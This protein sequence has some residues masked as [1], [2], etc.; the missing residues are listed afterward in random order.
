MFIYYAIIMCLYILL[1]K[2]VYILCSVTT[3]IIA[4]LHHAADIMKVCIYWSYLMCP[5]WPS[6]VIIYEGAHVM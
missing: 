2:C 5:E 4:T 6:N 3:L 1:L